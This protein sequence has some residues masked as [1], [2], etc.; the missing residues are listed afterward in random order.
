MRASR[1]EAGAYAPRSYCEGGLGSY[2]E[3][4]NREVLLSLTGPREV[5]RPEDGTPPSAVP[6]FAPGFHFYRHDLPDQASVHVRLS[7]MAHVSAGIGT[8]NDSVFRT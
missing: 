6:E 4:G 3:L 8:C 2:L 5:K 7:L 1:L